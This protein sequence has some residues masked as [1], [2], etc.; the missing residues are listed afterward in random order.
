M[1]IIMK[2]STTTTARIGEACATNCNGSISRNVISYQE[3]QC[4][5]T[6]LAF[7]V[8]RRRAAARCTPS[9]TNTRRL[10]LVSLESLPSHPLCTYNQYDRNASSMGFV[11]HFQSMTRVAIATIM[12]L[13]E[14]AFVHSIA[15][16]SSDNK[17]KQQ[18]AIIYDFITSSSQLDK[19][20]YSNN[21]CCNKALSIYKTLDG[22]LQHLA[23]QLMTVKEQLEQDSK[24]NAS[25]ETVMSRIFSEVLLLA[26]TT[27]VEKSDEETASTTSSSI[28][29]EEQSH[30]LLLILS[31]C[32]VFHRLV[33]LN[34]QIS[35]P[36]MASVCK[37]INEEYHKNNSQLRFVN[38]VIIVNLLTLLEGILDLIHSPHPT[39]TEKKSKGVA[40]TIMLSM[41]NIFQCELNELIVPIPI[42]EMA[43]FYYEETQQEN[44]TLSSTATATGTSTSSKFLIR[45][46]LYDIMQRLSSSL[47]AY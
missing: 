12:P 15:A 4:I 18:Q 1:K 8:L 45:L 21:N 32:T 27:T 5:K 20:Q 22:V 34:I 39:S 25:S 33:Y 9:D 29:T 38:D 13:Y 2:D 36:I 46:A 28:R 41:L 11:E 17:D 19:H 26:R 44:S 40:R 7:V 30:S 14:R 16:S 31:I 35:I 37:L 24:Y 47:V 43:K 10:P 23:S 42:N 3:Q 6:A